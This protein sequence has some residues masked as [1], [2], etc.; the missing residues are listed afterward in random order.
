MILPFIKTYKKIAT[1]FIILVIFFIYFLNKYNNILDKKNLDI[2][3]SN[4]IQIIENELEN[5]K[6]QAL[7]LALMFSRNQEIVKSLENKNSIE[8]KKEL[9]KLLNIIETYRKNRIDVQIHTVSQR[10]LQ[11]VGK[12]KILD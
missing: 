5:Q 7:S 10:Y 4:Q 3:V 2:F 1:L 6:N 12:I 11:E 8:L 9:L